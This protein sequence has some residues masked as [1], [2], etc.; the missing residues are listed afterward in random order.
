M[1]TYTTGFFSEGIEPAIQQRIENAY[2]SAKPKVIEH[3]RKQYGRDAIVDGGACL[4]WAVLGCKALEEAGFKTTIIQAGSMH[5]MTTQT[6]QAGQVN[7]F[8]YEFECSPHSAAQVDRGGLPEMHV[9]IAL[10]NAGGMLIDFA[11]EGLLGQFNASR[12]A[13]IE[14]GLGHIM[15]AWDSDLP[16][17]YFVTKAGEADT[18]PHSCKYHC[19]PLATVIA[20]KS[21][22][23]LMISRGIVECP[24]GL[25]VPPKLEHYVE[26]SLDIFMGLCKQRAETDANYGKLNPD[27]IVVVQR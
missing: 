14:Q 12:E 24:Q 4:Y 11:T 25:K 7:R 27:E 26:A 21:A 9:W 22:R 2:L 19:D 13:A 15:P 18:H 17:K 23:D 20:V 5:W 6:P 8:G 16:P 1:K 10:Q 3:F